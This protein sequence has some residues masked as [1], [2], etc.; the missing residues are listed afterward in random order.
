MLEKK[1]YIFKYNH[2]LCHVHKYSAH[3]KIMFIINCAGKVDPSLIIQQLI[4][5]EKSFCHTSPPPLAKILDTPLDGPLVRIVS[6]AC[7]GLQLMVLR[8]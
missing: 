5:F 2:F 8:L 4:K 1:P 7:I 6:R 3:F